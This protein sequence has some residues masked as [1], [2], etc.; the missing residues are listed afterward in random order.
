MEPVEIQIARLDERYKSIQE[1]ME[2]NEKTNQESTATLR[3][4]ESILDRISSRVEGVENALASAKPTINE[5]VQF[6]HK[7][8][9]AGSFG[10]WVW[11][12]AGVLLS[13]VLTVREHLTKFISGN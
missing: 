7:V 8:I 13:Y 5:F 1:K 3:R 4:L 6:K 12:V 11:L 2:Q 9:G 10:K